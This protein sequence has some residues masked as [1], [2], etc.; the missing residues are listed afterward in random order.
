[1]WQVGVG[2]SVPLWVDRRQRNQLEEARVRVEAST[3]DAEAVARE[4]ELRTRERLAQLG[5]AL[6]VAML[7]R[8]QILPLDELSLES[9]LTSYQA[10]GVPFITVLDAL[11]AVYN[12]RTLYA[13]RLA[14]AAKWRAAIDEAGLLPTAMAGPA[15]AVGTGSPGGMA[16]GATTSAPS[17]GSDAPMPSMR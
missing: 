15:M 5:A 10:G 11:N 6:R 1:M 9:A 2:V 13:G 14:E 7:Y 3:A 4:L 12:D 16:A 17:S 8:D